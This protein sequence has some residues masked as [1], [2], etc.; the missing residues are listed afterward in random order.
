MTEDQA[1]RLEVARIAM[2]AALRMDKDDR[3]RLGLRIK[4]RSDIRDRF[5]ALYDCLLS[6]VH[7]EAQDAEG[8][9]GAETPGGG[10]E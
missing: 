7:N 10:E 5:G 2:D 9:D 6:R 8:V 3:G 4:K 1:L